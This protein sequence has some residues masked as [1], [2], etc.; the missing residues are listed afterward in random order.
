MRAA[1]RSLGAL[2]EGNARATLKLIMQ[3]RIR[4]AAEFHTLLKALIGEL[5]QAQDHFGLVRDLDAASE[6]YAR[7][8]NESRTFWYLTRRAHIDAAVS[9]LCKAYDQNSRSLNLRNLLDTIEGNLHH[10]D[11]AGFRERRKDSPFVA[12]LAASARRPDAAQLAADKELVSEKTNPLVR[13]L[14]M[15]RHWFV[16]H[17]DAGKIL[18]GRVLGEE[19][20]LTFTDVQTLLDTGLGIVNRY[21]ILFIAT[22]HMDRMIGHDDYLKVLRAVRA[23]L[24]AYEAQVGAR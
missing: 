17:R 3:I 12:S 15:W 5:T 4:D 2:Y 1:S 22:S 20:P 9:R 14:M 21:S 6:E 13:N 8:L 24:D 16:A 11:E 18:N 10:F 23:Q 19:Y 7:E